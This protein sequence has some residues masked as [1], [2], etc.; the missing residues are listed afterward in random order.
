MALAGIRRLV[1]HVKAFEQDELL[2]IRGLVAALLQVGGV[3]P[4]FGSIGT[5]LNFGFDRES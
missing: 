1:V 4:S 3:G 5:M 2:A